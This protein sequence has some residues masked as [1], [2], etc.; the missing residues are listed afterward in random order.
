MIEVRTV[1]SLDELNG[2]RMLLE[3]QGIEYKVSENL[4]GFETVYTAN[5]VNTSYK[6]LVW[7]NEAQAVMDFLDQRFD[8]PDEE[9]SILNQ[10]D[11]AD[12]IDIIAYP[13]NYGENKTNH[14]AKIL[15]KRGMSP[16]EMERRAKKKIREDNMPMRVAQTT[17]FFAYFLCITGG[18]FGILVGVF[19][20]FAKSKHTKTGERYYSHDDFSRRQGLQIMIFAVLCFVLFVRYFL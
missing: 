20:Y 11:D 13:E 5:P 2:I 4:L 6:I 14:A 10:F 16:D 19:L 3:E 8:S 18:L 1:Y 15:A 9:A 7:E 17:L 12:L